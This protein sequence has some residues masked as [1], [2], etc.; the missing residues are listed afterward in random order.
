MAKRELCYLYLTCANTVEAGQIASSLLEKRLIVCAKQWPVTADYWWD[1]QIEHASEVM[2]LMESSMDL[3]NEVE[4]EVAKLHSYETF[5]LEAVPID[6]VSK[7]ALAWLNKEI[8][9]E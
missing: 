2:L 6:K 5:V 3:F 8:E 1:G 4:K 7:K 9:A